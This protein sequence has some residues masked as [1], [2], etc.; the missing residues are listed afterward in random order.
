MGWIAVDLDATLIEWGE[1]TSNPFDIRRLGNPI[2]KMVARVQQHLDAGETVRIFTARVGPLP[3]EKALQACLTLREEHLPL[4][5]PLFNEATHEP[6][7]YWL[8]YQ[9][10]LIENLC[11]SLFNRILVVTAVKDFEM[12]KLYDDRATQVIPN[13]GDTLEELHAAAVAHIT[14]IAELDTQADP[15]IG[16]ILEGQSER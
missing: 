5:L 4:G 8:E 15:T 9:R 11:G 7:A 16:Q 6:V 10:T 1:G 2:P 12:W 14:E 3:L 13:T